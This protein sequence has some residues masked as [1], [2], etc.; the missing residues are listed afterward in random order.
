MQ[1]F[2]RILV[3]AVLIG[4]VASVTACRREVRHEPMKLGA[5]VTMNI[6]D[7]RVR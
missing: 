2:K 7:Q 1:S 4:A 5:D 3:T 6:V